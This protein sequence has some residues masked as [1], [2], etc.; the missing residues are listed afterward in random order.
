MFDWLGYT[1]IIL[2][3]IGFL[4]AFVTRSSCECKDPNLDLLYNKIEKL[5]KEQQDEVQR[6][7]DEYVN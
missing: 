6:Q 1:I 2:G 3:F 5:S 7:V 4:L